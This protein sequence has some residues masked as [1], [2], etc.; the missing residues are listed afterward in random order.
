M[1]VG[2]CTMIYLDSTK[3]EGTLCRVLFAFIVRSGSL[4]ECTVSRDYL[5]I[6]ELFIAPSDLQAD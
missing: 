1:K 2:Q 5:F 3:Y 4:H 6:V